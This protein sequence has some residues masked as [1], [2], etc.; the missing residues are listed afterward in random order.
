MFFIN[1]VANRIIF[2]KFAAE[3]ESTGYDEERI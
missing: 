3:K 1:F 2:C